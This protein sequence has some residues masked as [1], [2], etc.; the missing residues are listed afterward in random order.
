[1]PVSCAPLPSRS[2]GRCPRAPPTSCPRQ[3]PLRRPRLGRGAHPPPDD[4]PRRL[5]GSPRR[6]HLWPQATYAN[7]RRWLEAGDEASLR[8]VFEGAPRRAARRRPTRLPMGRVDSPCPRPHPRAPAAPA[9]RRVRVAAQAATVRAVVPA[10]ARPRPAH[11]RLGAHAV[12]PAPARPTPRR[13]SPTGATT[14]SRPAVG[15]ARTRRL[16][17]G[18]PGGPRPVRRLGARAGRGPGGG[19]VRRRLVRQ[20]PPGRAR[21]RRGGDLP[22]RRGG[23]CGARGGRGPLVAALLGPDRGPRSCPTPRSKRPTTWA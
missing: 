10:D 12:Q 11:R 17:P 23:L 4:Q 6:D 21:R 3:R 7:L 18:P 14:A 13:S 19:G 15:T 9:G 16:V 8:R 20:R 5:L 1:M 22:G 2:P